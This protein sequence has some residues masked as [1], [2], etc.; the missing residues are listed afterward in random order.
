MLSHFGSSVDCRKSDD[1]DQQR[2]FKNASLYVVCYGLI[3]SPPN[4]Y[5]ESLTPN[6][7]VFGGRA[8]G[9]LLDEVMAHWL[10]RPTL[11]RGPVRTRPPIECYPAIGRID[12]TCRHGDM[13]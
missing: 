13:S 4:P 8:F 6:V 5:V 1:A 3:V 12:F 10:D 7:M 11:R 9:P 2:Q